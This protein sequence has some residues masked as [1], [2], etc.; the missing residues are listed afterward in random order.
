MERACKLSKTLNLAALTS[1]GSLRASPWPCS[2]FKTCW[3]MD[4]VG[5]TQAC[6]KEWAGTMALGA[7]VAMEATEWVVLSSLEDFRSS[8][9]VTSSSHSSS[10]GRRSSSMAATSSSSMEGK[11]SSNSSNSR[12]Q[13]AAVISKCRRST[14]PL[15]RRT[16]PRGGQST[17]LTTASCT[18]TMPLLVFPSGKDRSNLGKQCL[19]H[20][21]LSFRII[22][23]HLHIYDTCTFN[24]L[25]VKC[26][27]SARRHCCYRA[28][29][30]NSGFYAV[31]LIMLT[32]S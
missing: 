19:C 21:E 30:S 25:L 12:I 29:V 5:S 15:L 11:D 9:A 4:L 26:L 28:F 16:F 2:L 6:S 14:S 3:P 27:I 13:A 20:D 24:G 23:L 10:T 17:K 18:G 22:C 8:T 32:S 7:W 1:P 31:L